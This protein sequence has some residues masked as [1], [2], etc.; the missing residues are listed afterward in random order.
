MNRLF[1]TIVVLSIV[2]ILS[3]KPQAGRVEYF[4]TLMSGKDCEDRR[5]QA[6]QFADTDLK[7]PTRD[8][9]KMG[10]IFEKY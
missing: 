2:F 10:A 1:I 4:K 5:Y 7:C 8:P 3:Y 9:E 6:V